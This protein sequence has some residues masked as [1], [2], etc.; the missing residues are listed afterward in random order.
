MKIT[1][2]VKYKD[3][4]KETVGLIIDERGRKEFLV[5]WGSGSQTRWEYASELAI[6]T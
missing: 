3:R 4:W 5:L 2:L 6:V 1:D